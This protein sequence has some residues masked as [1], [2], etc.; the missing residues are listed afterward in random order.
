MGKLTD[1]TDL[2]W[3]S[4]SD[5]AREIG[6]DK[7]GVSRKVCRWEARGLLKTRVGQSGQKLV[8]RAEFDRVAGET[9]NAVREANGR[10]ARAAREGEVGASA[11][12]VVASADL[13]LSRAQASKT[14]AQARLAQ[15]D[16]AQRLGEL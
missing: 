6:R 12:P 4:I 9:V 5:L 14:A 15:L 11:G 3:V 16:L 13:V 2:R 8:D 7:G 1:E 10:I